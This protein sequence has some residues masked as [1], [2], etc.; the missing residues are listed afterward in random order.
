MDTVYTLMLYLIKFGYDESDIFIISEGIPDDIAANISH[1]SFSKPEFFYSTKKDRFVEFNTKTIPTNLKHVCRL[2]KLKGWLFFKTFNKDV[3]VYGQGH[4]KFSFP[5]YKWEHNAIIEDGL[6]NYSD[7]KMPYR[8]KHPGLA[9]FLGFY[10]KFF[11]EGFGTHENIKRIYLTKTDFPDIIKDKVEVIDPESLWNSK[12]DAEKNRILDIFNIRDIVSQIED[13]AVVLI[14]QPFVED[15]RF[16]LEEE[17]ELYR[18]F[19]DKYPNLII[20]THP[21]ESKDYHELLGDDIVVIDRPFPMELLKF[22]GV[23]IG[24]IVTVCSTVAVNFKDDCEIEIYDGETSSKV[25]NDAINLLWEKL[26]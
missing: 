16:S 12:S 26:E 17:L 11:R 21:R 10:F 25:I 5:L 15:G 23:K 13:D 9:H 18:H 20:K 14:T 7:L 1:Y 4:L 22:V 24:R 2:L 6:G 3:E 19:L 8:F